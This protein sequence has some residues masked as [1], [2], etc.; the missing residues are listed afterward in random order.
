MFEIRDYLRFVL[1]PSV[2]LGFAAMM[3]GIAWAESTN[4]RAA[5]LYLPAKVPVHTV[6]GPIASVDR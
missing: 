4:S 1:Y 5:R 3:Y 2:L 6:A